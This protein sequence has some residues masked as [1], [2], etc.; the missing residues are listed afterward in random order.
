MLLKIHPLKSLHMYVLQ[1]YNKILKMKYLILFVSLFFVTCGNSQET[2]FI[3]VTDLKALL[4]KEKI[5][6]L[7]IRTP[8]EISQGSIKT[9]KFVNLFDANFYQKASAQLDKSKPVYV[10]C[11]TSNRSK[12]ASKILSEKGFKIIILEGGYS[13]WKLKN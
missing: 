9:A 7:D 5:Q 10:Y 2:K 11:N 13:S 8:E 1:H 6:L 4:S 3:S 12:S